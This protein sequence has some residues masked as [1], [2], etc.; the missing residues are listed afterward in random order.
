MKKKVLILGCT[1]SVGTST[2]NIIREFP[3]HFTVCGLTAHS[4]NHALQALCKEFCCDNYMLTSV[5]NSFEH[6]IK[7]SHADI[8]VNAIA[9][10]AGLIPSV[11]CL[12][13]GIDLAL[14]NKETVVMAG[15]II[16]E[17]ATAHNCKIIPVD[18]EHSAVFSLT[19]HYGR[20][21]IAKIVLTAS[22]GPFLNHSRDD[23]EHVSVEDALNHP[24]WNMGKKITI[25]SATLANKGLEVIEACRLFDLLPEQVQVSVHPQSLVHSFICTVDGDVYAQISKPDMRRPIVTALLWPEMTENTIEKFDFTKECTMTFM[26]PRSDDFP[27]LQLA[28]DAQ[29]KGGSYTI[30]YNAA[31]EVAVDLFLQKKIGFTDIAKSVKSVLSLDW[32]KKPVTVDDV[33]LFNNEVHAKTLEMYESG[34]YTT[35]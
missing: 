28:F 16:K 18:S 11:L 35:F 26:P 14:A 30:A 9:G 32:S 6:I 10:S 17:L 1:G 22:G 24:T 20:K 19:E 2:L 8:A 31:N 25:D 29:K 4:N 33:L 34:M 12:E 3:E 5:E 27:L 13:N 21:N 23:L 7:K 15:D